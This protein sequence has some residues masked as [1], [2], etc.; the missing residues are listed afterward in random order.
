VL[1][2]SK[3]T[4]E[5]HLSSVGAAVKNC[6]YVKVLFVSTQVSVQSVWGIPDEKEAA[7]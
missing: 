7:N 2:S 6:G 5:V 1:L 4:R 3:K